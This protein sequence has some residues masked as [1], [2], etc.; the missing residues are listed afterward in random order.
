HI[1]LTHGTNDIPPFCCGFFGQPQANLEAMAA[2][3]KQAG[4]K[5]IMGEFT[6]KVYGTDI[7]AGY[8]NMYAQAA[9]NSK[10]TYVNLVKDTPY[11]G[12]NYFPDGIHFRDASQDSIKNSAASAL[13]PLLD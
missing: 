13:F 6:L 5:V 12:G 7:A 11:D 10:S 8:T 3:A 9:K 2:L 4:V 1:I